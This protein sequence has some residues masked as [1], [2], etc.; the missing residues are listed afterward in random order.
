MKGLKKLQNGL[1][2]PAEGDEFS[3]DEL[4][5]LPEPVQR[6]F[7][8]SIAVGTPIATS[9]RLWMKGEIKVKK[10]LPFKARQVLSPHVGFVWSGRAAGLIVGSDSYFEGTG[11]LDWKVAGL[12]TVAHAEGVDVSRS[13]AGRAGAEAIWLPTALLPRFGVRW[14]AEGPDRITAAFSLGEARLRLEL[15]I[16]EVGRIQ[17]LVFE[18]WGDPDITGTFGE[19]PFGGVITEYENF[20]GLTIPSAGRLG[21]RFGTDGWPEG[22]F[23]RYEITGLQPFL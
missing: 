3:A 1:L 12:I 8:A 9:A 16:D 13:A 11:L 14:S 15:H 4:N 5:G 21:W 18:R 7:N 17:S 20:D 23:F 10:W 6:Y 2:R 22:E 19:Y